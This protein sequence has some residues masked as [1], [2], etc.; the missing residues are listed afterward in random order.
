MDGT[1]SRQ[2]S[3]GCPSRTPSCGNRGLDTAAWDIL[4]VREFSSCSSS[5]L[6]SGTFTRLITLQIPTTKL[7]FVGYLGRRFTPHFGMSLTRTQGLTTLLQ[8][9]A[10]SRPSCMS[11]SLSAPCLSRFVGP[12]VTSDEDSRQRIKDCG[13]QRLCL[14]CVSR[15]LVY[16]F[17][18]L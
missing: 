9:T 3:A 15:S 4:T 18:Q 17:S 7:G 5:R 16:A 10:R 6:T 1:G 2:S 13:H 11:H 12:Q 14:R 8:A